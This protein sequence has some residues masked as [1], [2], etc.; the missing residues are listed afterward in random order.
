MSSHGWLYWNRRYLKAVNSGDEAA[1]S[2]FFDD[3]CDED[4]TFWRSK[5]YIWNWIRGKEFCRMLADWAID[6]YRV[7]KDTDEGDRVMGKVI[8]LLHQVMVT[9]TNENIK[10]SLVWKITKYAPILTID[11]LPHIGPERLVNILD[12]DKWIV[13]DEPMRHIVLYCAKQKLT[14][15]D[16]MAT[17]S[18]LSSFMS[19]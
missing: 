8:S 10:R 12:S 17:I 13:T 15:A 5:R 2:E 9:E 11:T 16:Q 18:N 7:T 1:Q 6:W 3:A 4:A 19:N 14:I